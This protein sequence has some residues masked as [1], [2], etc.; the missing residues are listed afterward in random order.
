MQNHIAEKQQD[1]RALN[2]RALRPLVLKLQN[3]RRARSYLLNRR[4]KMSLF[5]AQLLA[6][7]HVIDVRQTA[8]F[9]SVKE[10]VAKCEAENTNCTVGA[11][12][13]SGSATRI[14][15]DGNYY[16]ITA[17]HVCSTPANPEVVSIARAMTVYVGGTGN[18]EAI[19]NVTLQLE[20]D[21]CLM[22]A[23]PGPARRVAKKDP[24][25]G[26]AVHVLAYPGG[27]FVPEALPMYDGRFGGRIQN[28][29]MSTIPVAGGSSGSGVINRQGELVGVVSAVMR[30][31]NHFTIA[32]CLEQVRQFVGPA[33]AQNSAVGAK[34]T[35]AVQDQK[36]ES[37]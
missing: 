16:W 8:G 2:K 33:A 28:G 34:G 15:W 27:I 11:V 20:S 23:S 32:A 9:V 36:Q 18:A 22:E 17:A 4:E 19:N 14:V 21:L 5:L 35:P 3:F 37:E 13:S 10:I 12:T 30:T 25:L 26:A 1:Y 6:C 31:F 24:A 29:C 7:A